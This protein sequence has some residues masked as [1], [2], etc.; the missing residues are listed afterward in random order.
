MGPQAKKKLQALKDALP[1]TILPDNTESDKAKLKETLSQFSGIMDAVQDL[2]IEQPKK[3]KE[4]F[5][6]TVLAGVKEVVDR[7]MEIAKTD[8]VEFSFLG[9]DVQ[10]LGEKEDQPTLVHPD[11]DKVKTL[12]DERDS[13]DWQGS[14]MDCP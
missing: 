14:T 6:Q 8:K 13:G 1:K 4:E 10:Y 7:V 5:L 2:C 9:L 11:T 3:V 12:E